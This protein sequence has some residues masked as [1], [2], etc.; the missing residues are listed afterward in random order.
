MNK[1]IVESSQ[2]NLYYEQWTWKHSTVHSR[3][4]TVYN[5]PLN[6][7]QKFYYLFLEPYSRDLNY[8]SNKFEHDFKKF[9]L[10]VTK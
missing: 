4:E 5:E 9:F 8:A 3:S 6:I 1:K 10:L 2:T 7:G